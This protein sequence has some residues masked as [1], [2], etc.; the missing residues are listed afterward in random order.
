MA[1]SRGWRQ[2][3]RADDDGGSGSKHSGNFGEL[4]GHIVRG[5]HSRAAYRYRRGS[6][7]GLSLEN[8]TDAAETQDGTSRSGG[9]KT[10]WLA[11]AN[12]R[13]LADAWRSTGRGAGSGR[14]WRWQVG[15][16]LQFGL[17]A[18]ADAS[19]S[20]ILYC[21]T[22][23]HA[24]ITAS[25]YQRMCCAVRCIIDCRMYLRCSLSVTEPETRR[26]YSTTCLAVS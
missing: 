8:V 19:T 7:G 20:G 25:S 12:Q 21:A 14:V 11:A 1:R 22:L 23:S 17:D 9:C 18:A 26:L 3:V 15:R 6:T 10:S 24:L 16:Y 13:P 4:I 5:Y 2:G